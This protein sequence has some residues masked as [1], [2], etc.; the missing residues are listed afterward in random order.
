MINLESMLVKEIK[1][2]KPTFNVWPRIGVSVNEQGDR[3]FLTYV[4]RKM[5]DTNEYVFI[6]CFYSS[7][8]SYSNGQIGM[9]DDIRLNGHLNY[10]TNMI[11]NALSINNYKDFEGFVNEYK[12]IKE[13]SAV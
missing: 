1:D 6:K 4:R 9:H 11:N 3:E 13:L 7:F 2:T 8:Y 5:E 12:F 10:F